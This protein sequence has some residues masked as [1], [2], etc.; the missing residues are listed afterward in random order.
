[1]MSGPT[2]GPH[3]CAQA[4]EGLKLLP[5]GSDEALKQASEAVKHTGLSAVTVLVS[6]EAMIQILL[7]VKCCLPI[8]GGWLQPH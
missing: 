3:L 5:F 1:M 2:L 6:D 8:C 4:P 7:T